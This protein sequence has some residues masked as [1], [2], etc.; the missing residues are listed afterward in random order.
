MALRHM[1]SPIDQGSLPACPSHRVVRQPG[2]RGGI[3]N[4]NEAQ[5]PR[6]A[7]ALR[8]RSVRWVIAPLLLICGLQ[9]G[10]SVFRSPDAQAEEPVQQ[11]RVYWLEIQAP[12]DV[13][14][15]LTKYLDLARFQVVGKNEEVTALE[16]ERLASTAPAQV[17]SLLEAQGYFHS[18]QRLERIDQDEPQALPAMRL[19]VTPGPMVQV[20]SLDLQITGPLNDA[21]AAHDE[22]ANRLMEELRASWDLTPGRPFNATLWSDAKSALENKARARGYPLAAIAERQARVLADSDEVEL[23]CTLASGPLALLG[24][25]RFEGLHRFNAAILRPLSTFSPGTPYQDRLLMDYADR[26]RKMGL[27]ESVSVELDASPETLNAAPVVVRV[28]ENSLQQATVGFGYNDR[29]RQTL[30]L[31]HIHRDIFDTGWMA[32]NKIELGRTKQNGEGEFTSHPRANGDSFFLGYGIEQ[33]NNNPLSLKNTSLLRAGVRAEGNRI[34]RRIFGEWTDSSTRNREDSASNTRRSAVTGNYEWIWRDLDNLLLPTEGLS[35]NLRLSGGYAIEDGGAFGRAYMR[36][37]QYSPLGRDWYGMARLEAGNVI[38][39]SKKVGVPTALLFT[40]GGNNSVRGYGD[41]SLGPT[42]L[43]AAQGGRT[44]LTTSLEV[45]HVI[46][47]RYPSIWGAA[48][49][50]GGSTADRWSELRPSWGYGLGIRWR[51]PVGPLSLDVAY[52]R[53]TQTF[54]THLSLGVV[55]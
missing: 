38:A 35:A 19:I 46:L 13:R 22:N 15:L 1:P 8:K 9:S 55:F 52:G 51:T 41:E 6:A 14:D 50:D 39:Q 40:A 2:L 11:Q 45:S 17:K 54:R 16:I 32:R 12:G 26:L 49:L 31:E 24:E 34:E 44:L 25:L 23:S 21:A 10:C 28:R 4:P 29:S 18:Q 48:F 3:P 20:K 36:L 33:D 27:F 30:S 7:P 42:P 43:A 5:E 53:S 47:E 37:I